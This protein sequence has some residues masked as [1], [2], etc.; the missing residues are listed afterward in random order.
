MRLPSPSSLYNNS[1][2]TLVIVVSDPATVRANAF[3]AAQ[4]ERVEKA[5]GQ[6]GKTWPNLGENLPR[7]RRV[8]HRVAPSDCT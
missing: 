3:F 1:R 8:C 6:G 2:E 7:H 5:A 4:T